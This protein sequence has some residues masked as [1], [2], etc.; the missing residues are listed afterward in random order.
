MKK[1]KKIIG[2][3]LLSLF[4]MVCLTSCI[5]ATAVALYA[6]LHEDTEHQLKKIA[7]ISEIEE[8]ILHDYYGGG[9]GWLEEKT[10]FSHY[11][12]FLKNGGFIQV[13]HLTFDFFDINDVKVRYTA[14]GDYEFPD[15]L[16]YDD[17]SALTGEKIEYLNTVIFY[18]DLIIAKIQELDNLKLF[19]KSTLPL[20]KNEILEDLQK[21][22]HVKNVRSAKFKNYY[23][24]ENYYFY[25][26][27][28]DGHE[29]LMSISDVNR[30]EGTIK[31]SF[32][33]IKFDDKY[34]EDSDVSVIDFKNPT[35]EFYPMSGYDCLGKYNSYRDFFDNY[36]KM[37][38][39]IADF[40]SNSEFCKQKR[41]EENPNRKEKHHEYIELK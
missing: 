14:F 30:K 1:C 19:D 31:C 40:I 9:T 29:I 18:Y 36:E 16:T 33:I 13:N 17:L 15:G 34:A 39:I 24:P 28:D 6:V 10:Y 32:D 7:K 5:T 41:Y 35:D 12:F 38:D 3:S 11:E 2:I 21:M 20:R 37:P 8:Y 23:Y 4:C 22:P 25:L 26:S 27:M